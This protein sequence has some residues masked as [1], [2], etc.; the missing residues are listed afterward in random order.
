LH[1][2]ALSANEEF[3]STNEELETA[4]EELQSAN[5]ELAT[6][7]DEL[8]TRNQELNAA[9]ETVREARD[10]AEAIV[11]TMRHP[12]LV[13]DR[14]LR[15]QH[16]NPAYYRL[17]RTARSDVEGR[18]LYDLGDRQWDIPQLR[19]LLDDT[20]ETT[21]TV[22][23]Y[24]VEHSF[25]G[26]GARVM[27][28]N[29]RRLRGAQSESELI[30]VGFEDATE[31]LGVAV[32]LAEADRRK[33]EF[34]AMLGHE[35]RNPLA[36]IRSV[37]D[38]M[39][40]IDIREEKLRWAREV[41]E[42]QTGQVVRLVDDLLE[43]SRISRGNLTLDVAE[44]ALGD[45]LE[46]AI[47]A[48]RPLIDARNH[49][50]ELR[51][52]PQR[53]LVRGD[54]V[55]LTQL[56]ANVLVNAAKYTPAGGEIGLSVAAGEGEATIT[57]SDNGRGIASDVLDRIFEPFAQMANASRTG[58]GIGLPLARRLAELHGGSLEAKSDGPG[59]GS[60]FIVRLPLVESTR[61]APP[62]EPAGPRLDGCRVLVVDDNADAADTLR[63]F[64][65]I[66]GCEVRCAYDGAAALALAE[67][68][69]ADV[70][71][72]DLALPDIDGYEVLRR[73]RAGPRKQKPVVALTGYA[74]PGDVMRMNEAGFDHSLRKPVGAKALAALIAALRS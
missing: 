57:V 71:L 32:A 20:L 29:A 58:L 9:N 34:L 33:D 1:E 6:T 18:H 19:R 61:A 39:R 59:T 66:A 64:L 36:P 54:L 35:L 26:L 24:R 44:M 41:L 49:R 8:R 50:L 12:L 38:V 25:E 17:F 5:E 51:Q 52:P 28:I 43:M 47:E 42:R 63:A 69:D 4:K 46:R 60:T 48:A 53:L 14:R 72:L 22:E 2:E 73:L 74:Q 70:V 40:G 7:N 37:L 16:A 30:L 55:R 21:D 27:L 23:D 65:E 45:A 3:Q 11:G 62:P 31:R 67:A 10:Y 13:L 68:F 56:F 15:V